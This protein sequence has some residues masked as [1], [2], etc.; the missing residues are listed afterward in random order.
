MAECGRAFSRGPPPGRIHEICG[1]P[2]TVVAGRA[3]H[4]DPSLPGRR[5]RPLHVTIVSDHPETLDGLRDDFEA[6]S[7]MSALATLRSQRF[8]TLPVI[9]TKEPKRFESLP[10]AE[11]GVL[12]LDVP[13]PVW[14]WTILDALRARLDS[15]VPE[16]ETLR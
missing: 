1:A 3:L 8:E 13:K 14:G 2:G 16:S 12:L 10:S 6:E 11:R 5:G 9:V 15:K 4:M 7:L